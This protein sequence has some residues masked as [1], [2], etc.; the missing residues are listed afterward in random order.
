VIYDAKTNK[1]IAETKPSKKSL[2]A[3][4]ESVKKNIGSLREHCLKKGI[5]SEADLQ[6]S[7]KN[8]GAPKGRLRPHLVDQLVRGTTSQSV[9]N[10]LADD[11]KYLFHIP[12]NLN[13]GPEVLQKIHEKIN[14]PTG[15]YHPELHPDY[16]STAQDIAEHRNAPQHIVEEYANHKNPDISRVA[17]KHLENRKKLSPENYQRI[18][19][20]KWNPFPVFDEMLND[21][22][23]PSGDLDWISDKYP[24][25][26]KY[27]H[28]VANHPN[29]SSETLQ[30]IAKAPI[31][32]DIQQRAKDILRIRH[33]IGKSESFELLRKDEAP[34]YD[35]KNQVHV[36]L[37]TNKLRELRDHINN[38]HGG[39]ANKNALKQQGYDPQALN[40]NHLLDSKG[41]LSADRVHQHIQSQPKLQYNVGH[42]EYGDFDEHGFQPDEDEWHR[43][44]DEAENEYRD[45]AHED[46]HR[47]GYDE[48]ISPSD[49]MDEDAVLEHYNK[50]HPELPEDH[51]VDTDEL[52]DHA[53]EHD[54]H[55]DND[56]YFPRYQ[57]ALDD[58]LSEATQGYV[59]DKMNEWEQDNPHPDQINP[60]AYKDALDDQQHTPEQS[61]VFQLKATPEHRKAMEDAGVHR[62][63]DNVMEASRYSGHPTDEHTLGWVRYTKGDDGIHIDEVQSDFGQ[64]LV[65]QAKKQAQDAVAN[66][67]ITQD[68]ANIALNRAGEKYPQHHLEKIQSILFG[69]KNP[70]QVI[71]EAFLQNLRD[72]GHAGKN[73]HIW[74]EVPKGNI[75]LQN[76]PEGVVT[77]DSVDN[78]RHNKLVGRNMDHWGVAGKHVENFLAQNNI[79]AGDDLVEHK[80]KNSPYS[81]IA[82]KYSDPSVIPSH[83]RSTYG[84]Q[85]PKLGYKP[86][87]YGQLKTQHN[88]NLKGKATWEQTLRKASDVTRLSTN[89]G[90]DFRYNYKPFH[91]MHPDDQRLAQKFF[92]GKDIGSYQYP[93][94]VITGRLVHSTRWKMPVGKSEEIRMPKEQFLKE[95]KKLLDVLRHPTKRKLQAEIKEQSGE[96]KEM[97]KGLSPDEI[98]NQGYRFKLFEG[99]RRFGDTGAG[100]I[101]YHKG[102]KIGHLAFSN[103]SFGSPHSET[104][105]SDPRWQRTGYFGVHNSEIAPE[106]RGKGIYQ[107]MLNL[108]NTHAKSKGGKGL[109]SEGYQRSPDAT[110]AWD[111]VAS[112]ANPFTNNAKVSRKLTA[113]DSDYFMK[114]EP[115]KKTR[116][117]MRFPHFKTDPRAEQNVQL[118]TTGRQKD[119]FGRKVSAAEVSPQYEAYVR[120]NNPRASEKA[121]QEHLTQQRKK[122]QSA[123]SGAF[124]RTR[125]GVNYEVGHPAYMPQ[126]SYQSALGGA[127]RSKFEDFDESYANKMV[128]HNKKR[129]EALIAYNAK[130][131]THNKKWR[132]IRDKV[133]SFPWGSQERD[134]ANRELE[135]HQKNAP[136][137]KA[138]RA[139][140]KARIK[141]EK[142][143]APQQKLRGQTVES[144]IEHEALH[145]IFDKIGQKYGP[146]VAL[147]ARNHVLGA[148]DQDVLGH[149]SDFIQGV[150][151]KAKSSHFNEELLTHARDLL[152]N[153]QKR[154]HFRESIARKFKDNPLQGDKVYHTT[155]AKLKK[156]WR[157][158]YNRSQS[159]KPED[160]SGL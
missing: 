57:E 3:H 63:F 94:N 138:P 155:I 122:V 71:H 67:Q 83:M 69:D 143:T 145:G 9:L 104:D 156:Q 95:H 44:R 92:Q 89:I 142:L 49:F 158:A 19:K 157:E 30:R 75:S 64:N 33:G 139:P 117:K 129:N 135:E 32:R 43:R 41:Q 97:K 34:S 25:D 37:G 105:P 5:A 146:A 113:K 121:I 55:L 17:Q 124:D 21:H 47:W 42:T 140:S 128:E 24:F 48:N 26:D 90:K 27:Q 133:R 98:H 154:K 109:M 91:E 16:H 100:V 51:E 82:V 108:A 114:A 87:T 103:R 61:Q 134:Q 81:N 79:Q 18:W 96:L 147:K 151:Y 80:K 150:G 54:L 131:D 10:R 132:E 66:G 77:Y 111:K 45:E 123:A 116:P 137:F 52:Y 56:K 40:I 28:R 119:I 13:A 62:T 70:N 22:T 152:V 99:G 58:A 29:A 107:H 38:V 125:L 50:T 136:K 6:K 148:F 14:T 8:Q 31:A 84:Q 60:K 76:K 86:S 118:L 78:Y 39:V 130:V 141:T 120:H 53:M 11:P 93:H 4:I 46:A 102:K 112:H 101:A 36:A 73:V 110:R 23:T 127:L 1:K 74:N 65:K 126:R 115:L 144:T 35:P 153:P 20:N 2:E 12:Y 149:I 68:Q 159:L 88:P 106:H 7:D 15:K 85:P 59:D 160:L 72:T